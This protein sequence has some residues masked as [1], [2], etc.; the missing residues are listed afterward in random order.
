M[1]PEP[2]AGTHCWVASWAYGLPSTALYLQPGGEAEAVATGL[3]GMVLAAGE[4]GVL[5]AGWV[6]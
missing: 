2:D 3:R 5:R 6:F 4:V 1:L